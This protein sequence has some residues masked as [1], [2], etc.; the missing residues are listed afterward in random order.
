MAARRD[1]LPPTMP[2]LLSAA[3]HIINARWIVDG[4]RQRRANAAHYGTP[5]CCYTYVMPL[6]VAANAACRRLRAA[7][8]ALTMP[9]ARTHA[10]AAMPSPLPYG[11]ARVIGYPSWIDSAPR[12]QRAIRGGFATLCRRRG[13]L[14]FAPG[15]LNAAL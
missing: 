11:Y 6:F 1:V 4:Y 13:A 10:A 15:A 9:R 12:R 5:R 14:S 7:P 3:V 2:V 8:C